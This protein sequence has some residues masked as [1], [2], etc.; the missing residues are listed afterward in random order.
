MNRRAVLLATLQLLFLTRVVGQFVVMTIAP[1]WLPAEQHWDSGFLSYAMLL[2]AQIV[3]LIVMTTHTIDAWRMRGRWHVTKENTRQSLRLLAGFYAVAMILRYLLTMTYVPELRWFG[4]TIPIFF[5]FVL[6]G[7]V[8]TLGCT[9]HYRS[10]RRAVLM[11]E[12]VR[13]R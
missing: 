3:I 7:Y 13:L 9:A 2:P 4:H 1:S 6:A 5:H 8:F 11:S 10:R 12:R